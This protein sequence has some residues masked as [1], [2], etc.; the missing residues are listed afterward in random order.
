MI[1]IGD[2]FEMLTVRGKRDGGMWDCICDCGNPS[3]AS[4][5][6]LK[7]KTKK[8]CGCLRQKSPTNLVDITGNR[9]GMLTVI[10]RAGRTKHDNATW[11]CRC[12]CGKEIPVNGTTLRRRQTVSCGCQRIDQARN[13]REILRTEKT[14][15]GV[16][17]PLLTKKV[18]S[19]SQ[20]GHKGI[21]KRFRKGREYYEINITVKGKRMYASAVTLEAA[22][23]K[24]KQLEERYHKPLID[25]QKKFPPT[26]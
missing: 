12:D 11:L 22:I 26:N 8:S 2:R 1:Q 14:V 21:Y 6:Q 17:L 4:T 10:E 20:T 15:D 25:K 9:Y 19:D 13:A 16:L 3:V 7:Y 23:E 5:T 24:R 18:R